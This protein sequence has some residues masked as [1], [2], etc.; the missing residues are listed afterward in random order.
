MPQPSSSIREL[1]AKPA[2]PTDNLSLSLSLSHS[3][4]QISLFLSLELG[5]V[6]GKWPP[7]SN[8]SLCLAALLSLPIISLRLPPLRFF[9]PPADGA[10]L[11]SEASS[12]GIVSSL[13]LL[14][15]WVTVPELLAVVDWSCVR[16]RKPLLKV[17]EF[18]FFNYFIYI[19]IQWFLMFYVTLLILYF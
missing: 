2:T 16:L 17:S 18:F 5:I 8:L 15:R 14:D 9:H 7:F 4:S 1:Q 10:C 12:S 11:S 13:A 6:C 19:Y 3:S